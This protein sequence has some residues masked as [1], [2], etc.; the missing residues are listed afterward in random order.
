MSWGLVFIS[1]GPFFF[2]LRWQY[3]GH[4]RR[5]QARAYDCARPVMAGLLGDEP[6]ARI[7]CQ[8]REIK[9]ETQLT[10]QNPRFWRQLGQKVAISTPGWASIA[11]L[12]GPSW[13]KIRILDSFSIFGRLRA[14]DSSSESS[15]GCYRG[16]ERLRRSILARMLGP[17]APK[18]EK[19]AIFP[20]KIDICPLFFR[21]I[22][23]GISFSSLAGFPAST[24][25]LLL[26]VRTRRAVCSASRGERCVWRLTKKKKVGR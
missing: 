14:Q 8:R 5:M 2:Y 23:R 11:R 18:N 1:T 21:A 26:A 9:K 16:A 4:W 10:L 25:S 7:I 6:I 17:G 13:A 22:A 15:P 3:S 20:W 12:S 19:R 24:S